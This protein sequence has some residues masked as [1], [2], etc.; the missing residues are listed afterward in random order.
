MLRVSWLNDLLVGRLGAER[1][2]LYS[3][4][5][6]K[7]PVVCEHE[8]YFV[9]VGVVAADSFSAPSEGQV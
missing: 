5:G 2:R 1:A 3:N 6:D 7:C 8:P 4:V 9:A